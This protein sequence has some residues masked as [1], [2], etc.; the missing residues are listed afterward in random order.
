MSRKFIYSNSSLYS[1]TLTG[2]KYVSSAGAWGGTTATSNESRLIDDSISS[3]TTFASPYDEGG[4]TKAGVRIDF[5][6][7]KTLTMIAV[8]CT[9]APTVTTLKL[10]GSASAAS[11]YASYSTLTLSAGWNLA[12]FSSTSKRY[13]VIQFED[14]GGSPFSETIEEILLGDV[15]TFD[16]QFALGNEVTQKYL[17]DENKAYSGTVYTNYRGNNYKK[18]SWEWPW[19]PETMK[20]SL[21]SFQ[22]AVQGSR[23]KFVYYDGSSYYWAKLESEMTYKEV[24][25]GVYNVS[26]K[27]DEMI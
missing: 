20:T 9:S 14:L 7:A 24:A 23:Y 16:Y 1:A 2:D 4:T 6:S 25:N 5:G 15:Y 21:D 18:W 26:V 13:W 22:S 19:I 10:Y 27:I 8:Y 17:V 3:S 11:G 12:T